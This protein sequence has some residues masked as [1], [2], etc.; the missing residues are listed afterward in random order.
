MPKRIRVVNVDDDTADAIKAFG[1]ASSALKAAKLPEALFALVSAAG[2][3]VKKRR[4]HR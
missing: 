1:E 4:R 2:R 3:V